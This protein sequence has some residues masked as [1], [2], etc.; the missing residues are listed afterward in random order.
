MNCFQ[1]EICRMQT[2]CKHGRFKQLNA[3]M[4]KQHYNDHKDSVLENGL[5]LV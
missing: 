1:K 5:R 4:A 2:E 3:I